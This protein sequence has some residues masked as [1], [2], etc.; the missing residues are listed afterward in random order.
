[1]TK[2]DLIKRLKY[3]DD[4]DVIIISDGIGWCNIEKVEQRVHNIV[5]LLERFP[6]F[7][8]N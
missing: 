1:M 7:S 8:N 6:V 4:D 3:F 2:K 5:L